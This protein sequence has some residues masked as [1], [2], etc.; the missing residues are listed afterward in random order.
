MRPSAGDLA[1]DRASDPSRPDRDGAHRGL[2]PPSEPAPAS[3]SLRGD[4]GRLSRRA[5]GQGLRRA[6]GHPPGP[7]HLGRA[8]RRP[9]ARRRR[10]LPAERPQRAPW[11][12]RRSPPAS[13][14]SA[15]SRWPSPI[16]KRARW[17]TPPTRRR[18]RPHGRVHLPLRGRAPLPQASRRRGALR[19][20]PALAHVLLQR[21]P[22]RPRAPLRLAS[23]AGARRRGRHRRHG[24]P[25]DR[26]RPL[27]PRRHRRRQRRE[28]HLRRRAAIPGGG[29]GRVETPEASAWV[30][31]FANGAIGT[32]DVSRAVAGRGG[33]RPAAVPGRRDPRHRRARR[34]TSSSTPS[35]SR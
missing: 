10:R 28:P 4:R 6:V 18:A 27:P 21:R 12:G 11:P 24:L 19:R 33:H 30:A 2:R 1:H 16:R 35:R 5:Q 9:R 15:R 25:H 8:R 17:P 32:F 20:D 34:S 7:R 13:M 3:G 22:A 26:R 31:E 14:S 23:P 29:A